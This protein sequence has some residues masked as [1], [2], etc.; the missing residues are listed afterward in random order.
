MMTVTGER[1]SP[2]TDTSADE[3]GTAPGDRRFRPDVEGLRAVAVLVVVLYHANMPGLPG[4]F[5]GVDVFFV[6]SGFVITGLLLRERASTDHTSLRSFYGRRVRRILPAATLVIVT[7][8]I[9]AYA[10]LGVIY[11]NP[12]A[13]AARWT[14]VFLANFHFANIGTDYLS[15]TLP[16]S[17]LQNFWSLAVEEQFYLVYPA[18]FLIAASVRSKVSLRARLVAVLIPIILISLLASAIQTGSS[19]STAFFSPLTRAWELALGALVAVATPALLRLHRTLATTFTWVGLAAIVYAAVTYSSSTSYPGTAVI[20]PVVGTALVIAGGSAVPEWG[21]EAILR[22]RPSQW[23]GRLS[24]SLYLWHWPIL[25]IA[26]EWAGH[27]GLPFHQNIG[28]LA[29]SFAVAY[30]THRLIENPVR[31]SRR[32]ARSR[33]LPIGL[34]ILLIG[35]SLSVATIALASHTGPAAAT[36]GANYGSGSAPFKLYTPQEV[37]RLVEAAPLITTLPSDL[38]PSLANVRDDWG[39]PS[40]PCWPSYAQTSVPACTFGYAAGTHTVVLY[41]D[42]HAAMWFDVM[43]LIASVAHWR[44]VILAKGDCPVVD[45]P[46]RSPPG[47]GPPGSTFTACERW[48][49]FAQQ[50]IR[51]IHPDLVILTQDPNLG[52]GNVGYQPSTWRHSLTNEIR[53]LPVPASRVIVLGDIPQTATGGPNCLSRNPHDVQ[54]CSSP[55]SSYISS[56][57]TAEQQ[58]AITT[59][60]KYIDLVPMFCSTVCT[61][62][63]GRYQ[64]YWD[65]FHV[66]ATYSIVLG[67]FLYQSIDLPGYATRSAPTPATNTS[68]TSATSASTVSGPT[69]AAGRV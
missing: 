8:V 48:H 14:A 33:W 65:P 6:I 16:P 41:G 60:A 18:I 19:P 69:A 5:V 21:V 39:G 23:I 35:V 32:L 49:T 28:W 7:T 26:A 13:V 22:I 31:H 43:N 62:V 17:P 64:P 38:T 30:A 58:A 34:G 9:A 45:L 63:I 1:G 20:V 4:G 29:L 12:T 54:R 15:A 55:D 42:S 59:G 2:P 52:P 61:D 57:S 68:T 24:Y 40:G 46:F 27:D 11:G 47:F 53:R 37:R 56:M 66:T 3:S 44:L 51:Q 50:R 36:T 25:I 10:I 67:D